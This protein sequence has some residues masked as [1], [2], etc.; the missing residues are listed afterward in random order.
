MIS[1]G[2]QIGNNGGM[3]GDN[4]NGLLQPQQAPIGPQQQVP[5]VPQQQDFGMIAQ[6]ERRQPPI[7]GQLQ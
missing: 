2:N 4:L 7:G 3:F 1:Q 6:Q 5:I